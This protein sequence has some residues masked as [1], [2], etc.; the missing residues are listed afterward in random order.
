MNWIDISLYVVYAL[1]LF[2]LFTAVFFAIANMVKSPKNAKA[3]LIGILAI[4]IIFGLSYV[5]DGGGVV[6]K[7]PEFPASALKQLG[8]S[9][10]TFYILFGLSFVAALVSTFRKIFQ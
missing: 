2:A 6:A 3:S 10:I 5:L 9:L 4:L 7:F 8:A 1:M